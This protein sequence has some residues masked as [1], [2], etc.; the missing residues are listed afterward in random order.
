[1]ERQP[2]FF[3]AP[4]MRGAGES[5]PCRVW[6]APSVLSAPKWIFNPFRCSGRFILQKQST[7][8]FFPKHS[9][10]R[11]SPLQV[12]RT[13]THQRYISTR[14][15]KVQCVRP[16]CIE[17]GQEAMQ[18]RTSSVSPDARQLPLGKGKPLRQ[19]PSMRGAGGSSPCRVWAAPSVPPPPSSQ[20][21]KSGRAHSLPL[22]IT[23]YALPKTL[24]I[25]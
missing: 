9:T 6:A 19:S 15:P 25:P 10:F 22:F 7:G 11:A 4:S 2:G 14:A 12:S 13:A 20:Q 23:L 16:L 21:Q 1:M 17:L 18:I 8:L 3:L 5:L 24:Q